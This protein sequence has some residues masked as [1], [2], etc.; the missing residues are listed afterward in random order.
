M[1]DS[2]AGAGEPQLIAGHVMSLVERAERILTTN[3]VLQVL[4]RTS[5]GA[6]KQGITLCIGLKIIPRPF[7][8]LVGADAFLVANVGVERSSRL[9][10]GQT[11]IY[12]CIQRSLSALLVAVLRLEGRAAQQRKD[13][14]EW[15]NRVVVIC[16][17][18]RRTT[19]KE[20]KAPMLVQVNKWGADSTHAE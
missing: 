17:R 3:L 13:P 11:K 5:V 18:R 2:T 1:W 12:R 16:G 20:K 6:E 4:P 9:L 15:F 19:R 14:T 7:F 8:L 10:V